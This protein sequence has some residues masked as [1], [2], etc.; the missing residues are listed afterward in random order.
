[1][2]TELTITKKPVPYRRGLSRYYPELPDY[3][4]YPEAHAILDATTGNIRD[5]LLF[6]VMW[7]AGLRVSEALSLT[8]DSIRGYDLRVLGKG[9]K[10]REIPVK[11]QLVNDLLQYAVSFHVDYRSRFFT[12]T[13]F[14]AHKLLNKYARKA[15]IQRKIHCHLLRHGYATNFLKQANNIVYLQEL[16]GHSSIESTRIYIRAALPDV[17][18]ALENVEM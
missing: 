14:Q 18:Q 9:N 5:Y 15:G 8:P 7:Y 1:M 12:I 3:I 6:A 13:R 10:W 16:L 17:R 11:P 4:S 2:T